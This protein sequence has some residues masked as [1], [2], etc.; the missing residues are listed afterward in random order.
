MYSGML[1]SPRIT[2]YQ[3][4]WAL[5]GEGNLHPYVQYIASSGQG[6]SVTTSSP[7]CFVYCGRLLK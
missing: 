6:N 7:I 3:A 4:H 5:Q 2:P 1:P